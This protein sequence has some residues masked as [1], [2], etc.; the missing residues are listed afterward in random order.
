MPIGRSL[1]E[2]VA[3]Q[4]RKNPDV[5]RELLKG[6]IECLLEGDTLT[7]KAVLRDYIN[8]TVGFGPLGEAL[9]RSPKSLM[10]M[11]STTGN[12]QLSNL[13]EI[14]SYL[15]KQAGVRSV[16]AF[17]KVRKPRKAA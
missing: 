5:S 10:R 8:G 15:Q 6:A 13:L 1:S 12:P 4:A 2:I 9:G 7:F 16:I 17:E 3:Q 11:L 14:T